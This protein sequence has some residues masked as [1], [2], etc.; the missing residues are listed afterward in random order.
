MVELDI[1]GRCDVTGQTSTYML[2]ALANVY[3]AS[4]RVPSRYSIH[5]IFASR[6]TGQGISDTT[7]AAQIIASLQINPS[8]GQELQVVLTCPSALTSATIFVKQRVAK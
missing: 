7:D 8:V 6:S 2:K 3:K 4:T 1:V 5:K